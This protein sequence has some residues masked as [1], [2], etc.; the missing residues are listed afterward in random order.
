MTRLW[1]TAFSCLF[2]LS[3]TAPQSHKQPTTQPSQPN[4]TEKQAQNTT[5]TKSKPRIQLPHIQVDPD[6]GTVS[7]DAQF[8]WQP[9]DVCDWLEL[10]VC[11]PNSR[12]YESIISSNAR[13]SHIHLALITLGFQ[14]GKPQQTVKQNNKWSLIP[15][16]GDPIQINIQYKDPKTSKLITRPVTDFILLRHTGKPMPPTNFLFTGSD[17]HDDLDGNPQYMADVNG[18]FISLV[19]FGDDLIAPPNNVNSANDEQRYQP[20]IDLL[21]P[22]KTPVKVI[23]SKPSTQSIAE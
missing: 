5:P 16:T 3:C 8:C 22:D 9:S 19:H 2:L 17:F 6:A 23:L 13:P 15:P 14:P 7:F 10:I 21:P 12:E 18:S 11:K 1:L 4:S 20:N